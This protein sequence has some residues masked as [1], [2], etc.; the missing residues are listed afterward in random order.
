MKLQ[1]FPKDR[2]LLAPSLLAADF[3]RLGEQVAAAEAAGA[4]ILHIDVMD[5]HF[6][7]NISMGPVVLESLRP[8]SGMLFDA[9]L[10]I[11]HPLRYL[12]AFAKA[13]ANHI[14]FH[15]E[16]P[17]DTGTV[18]EAIHEL[19][20]SAGISLKPGTPFSAV[21][22][23]LPQVEMLLVMSVEPGFGGQKFMPA[24][25]DKVRAAKEWTRRNGKALRIQIDGGIGAS[26]A[27]QV[28]EAGADCLVAGTAFFRHVEG[29]EAAAALLRG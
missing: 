23:W 28:R 21:E 15:V 4:E 16:C 26:N 6:V 20:L 25:L 8:R 10:M 2:V 14:T 27:A 17:D 19:G 3:A 24:Q 29:M 13:G 12:E 7:P 22:P 5:G 9:H 18:I 11:T 1:D